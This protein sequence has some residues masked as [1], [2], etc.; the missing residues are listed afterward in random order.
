MIN[1]ILTSIFVLLLI[2]IGVELIALFYSSKTVVEHNRN[3]QPIIS[4]TQSSP[5]TILEK[6]IDFLKKKVSLDQQEFLL[7]KLYSANITKS[8][9]SIVN[10]Y[11]GKIEE[12]NNQ[13]GKLIADTYEVNYDLLINVR[14]QNDDKGINFYYIKDEIGKIKY[15]DENNRQTDVFNSKLLKK[16]DTITVKESYDLR[17]LALQEIV[18][19]KVLP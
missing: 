10:E 11:S 9:T 2:V 8:N 13:Q 14:N 1:K 17:T 12:I 16:G 18:V 19:K 15:F 6:R 3:G 5:K 7:N 4:Q